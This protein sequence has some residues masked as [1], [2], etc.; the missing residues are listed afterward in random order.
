[1]RITELRLGT[2]SI[3]LKK[4]FKTALR[5]TDTV[6]TNIVA[7]VSDTGAVGYGDHYRRYRR[8]HHLYPGHAHRPGPDRP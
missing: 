5:S 6:T 7:L 3:P 8:V 2:L 1:M 4:P